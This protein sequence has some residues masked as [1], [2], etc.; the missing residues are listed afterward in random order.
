MTSTAI[1]ACPACGK[2]L[3]KKQLAF[4]SEEY[5]LRC[6]GCDARLAKR[7]SA[8]P[9]LSVG[10]VA[11]LAALY[12]L[13]ERS[14]FLWAAGSWGALLAFVGSRTARVSLADASVPD[15]P[16]EKIPPG[17]PPLD[18]HF[19]GSSGPPPNSDS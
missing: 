17:P 1:G 16:V 4:G 15:A 12:F 11:V 9:I 2:R 18:T 7:T 14:L 10:G 8:L 6:S 5:A 13:V 19:R 3:T